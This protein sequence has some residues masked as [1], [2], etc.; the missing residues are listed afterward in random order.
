M[1]LIEAIENDFILHLLDL[2][3]AE[4]GIDELPPY[5]LITDQPFIKGADKKS[6]GLFDG[7]SI[8]VVT[9]NRHPLDVARTL[10]HELTHWKQLLQGNEMNGED[11]SDVENE[12]NAV[13]GIIL[14]KF[15]ERY[16]EYFMNS[17]P[18]QGN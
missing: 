13:A 2:C 17:L 11:G 1:K 4:L 6:F 9:M 14:R 3:Q 12:A 10:A 15:G 18:M 8:R 16:P 7:H 5:E